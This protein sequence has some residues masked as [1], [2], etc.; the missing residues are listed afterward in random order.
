MSTAVVSSMDILFSF[1]YPCAMLQAAKRSLYMGLA[2]S[3]V[4]TGYALFMHRSLNNAPLSAS[5]LSVCGTLLVGCGLWFFCIEKNKSHSFTRGAVLGL[6][7]GWSSLY[8][9]I[10]GG[11]VLQVLIEAG[12]LWDRF[13]AGLQFLV[14]GPVLTVPLVFF[15]GW[16][17]LILCGLAGLLLIVWCRR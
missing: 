1:F 4:A 11:F 16:I 17:S 12:P 9:G 2:C 5:F 14:Y 13:I 7:T 6:L 15:Y 3:L 8:F 10:V